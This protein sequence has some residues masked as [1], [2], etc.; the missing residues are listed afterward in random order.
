VSRNVT[1]VEARQH[2]KI[3]L[4]TNVLID[5]FN[6]SSLLLR[7]IPFNQRATAVVALW[8][9]LRGRPGAPLPDEIVQARESWLAD[10]G[11]TGLPFSANVSKTFR[12][13]LTKKR[14]PG[15]ADSLIAAECLS[16]GCPLL[17]HNLRDFERFEGLLLVDLKM[18]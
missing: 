7:E 12:G 11:I 4:D 8:E 2:P 6:R 16:R 10:T 3:V 5:E 1:L 13:M 17:T 18:P 9:F 14:L 15:L